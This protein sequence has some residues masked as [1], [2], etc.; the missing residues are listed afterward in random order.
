[1]IIYNSIED[2]LQKKSAAEVQQIIND[3]FEYGKRQAIDFISKNY[4]Q[5]SNRDK[6]NETVTTIA[7]ATA[8]AAVGA[9]MT[10]RN[11]LGVSAGALS[12]GLAGTTLYKTKKEKLATAIKNVSMD[13][14]KLRN[15]LLSEN[16]QVRNKSIAVLDT[17]YR[18][19]DNTI[20]IEPLI[21]P[22]QL[23]FSEYTRK[24]LIAK[25]EIMIGK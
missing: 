13:I 2:E 22:L 9:V 6:L 8:G 24:H 4:L 19:T 25:F 14:E 17:Y 16:E 5:D 21:S 23:A 3:G 18:R 11:F 1:M 7:G 12:G 20:Q 15:D 10:R